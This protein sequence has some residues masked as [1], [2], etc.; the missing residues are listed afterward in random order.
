M[1]NKSKQQIQNE[2][3]IV[4]EK[5]QLEPDIR[6]EMD[7][8]YR[9]G[10]IFS[11]IAIELN[12]FKDINDSFGKDDAYKVL[13]FFISLM[14]NNLRKIDSLY[15][16]RRARFLI[17]LPQTHLKEASDIAGKIGTVVKENHC[18]VTNQPL[19]FSMGLSIFGSN[20][21]NSYKKL[22]DRSIKALNKAKEE[23]PN[24]IVISNKGKYESLRNGEK[25]SHKK[26]IQ[27]NIK[28]HCSKIVEG[29]AE[30]RIFIYQDII[31]SRMKRYTISPD[32]VDEELLRIKEAIDKVSEDLSKMQGL[33]EQEMNKEHGNIF[34]AHKLILQDSSV[35]NNIETELNE[36]LLNGEIIVR[37]TF[38]KMEKRFQLFED[39]QLQ[40]KAKDIRDIGGK[41][42]EKLQGRENNILSSLPEN[43]ILVSQRLLPSDTVFLD[44][45]NVK[46]I[47]TFEGSRGS[48]SAIL[49]RAL[50]IP[51]VTI[52][53]KIET[54]PNNEKIIIDTENSTLYLNPDALQQEK[55]KKLIQLEKEKHSFEDKWIHQT[56]LEI[57]GDVISIYANVSSREEAME[58]FA[59]D[60]RGVGLF[61]VEDIY[62][63]SSFMPD[64]DYLLAQFINILEPIKGKDI[65]IR[66][67][68]IGSDKVPSYLNLHDDINPALG[69]RGIRL[70]L[71]HRD[72]LNTQL[73]ACVR[74]N[75]TIP[76]RIMLPMVSLP[77]EI[78]T[79]RKL[80]KKI[81]QNES[82]PLGSMIE[83]P[84]AIFNIDGILESSDFISIGTNDLF[85]YTMAA[86]RENKDVANYFD[87]G[88]NVLK[89]TLSD[90]IKK[91]R[92]KGKDCTICG[93]I[94]GDDEY[95]SSLLN[96][97]LKKFSVLPI[98]VPRVRQE[99]YKYI[100]KL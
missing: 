73:S 47:V 3:T 90:I 58:A 23:G 26:R 11:I 28:I 7:R 10:S 65:T 91:S 24:S 37:D 20:R 15:R 76:I 32:E 14:G 57:N 13:Q 80:I 8:A 87:K 86:D 66:L 18:E 63:A 42:I 6:R 50:D 25:T 31:S 5:D 2:K 22:L 71:K 52:N 98:L 33:V 81:T 70:L 19:A 39:S 61:R 62:M 12:D 34:L 82:I 4:L 43:T 35:L 92:K 1:K 49:A 55:Y 41:V 67:L 46:G 9:Y 45:K 44:R 100:S 96:M 88:F 48:H 60:V 38:R 56:P 74:L 17:L 77:S 84:A 51:Y 85:Q 59:G 89:Q 94:A 68:D 40:E 72:L 21:T 36:R 27:N 75:R 93:E 79:V 30:G 29:Y 99:I 78:R 64:E 95:I 97:G 53:K 69:L 83:T 54:I 16:L